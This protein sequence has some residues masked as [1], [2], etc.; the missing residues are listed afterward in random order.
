[1]THTN[2]YTRK[3]TSEGE[4]NESKAELKAYVSSAQ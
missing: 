4:K 1:M 3:I 2:M